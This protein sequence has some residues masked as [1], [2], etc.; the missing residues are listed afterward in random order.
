MSKISL[1]F[2]GETILVD[3]PKSLSSLRKEISEL[4]CFSSEDAAEIILT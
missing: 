3:K 4:F 2:F 1:N